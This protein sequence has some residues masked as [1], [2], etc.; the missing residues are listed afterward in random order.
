MQVAIDELGSKTAVAL[1]FGG[2]VH[3]NEELT[4]GANIY[5]INQAKIATYNDERFST[6]L[7]AGITYHPFEKLFATIEA[8]KDVEY[9]NNVKVGLEYFVIEK[10]AVRTGF[11]TLNQLASFGLGLRLVRFRLRLGLGLV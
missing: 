5:N 2:L 10:L 7:K 9:K 3:V 4:I 8:E 1:E 6:V 11:T